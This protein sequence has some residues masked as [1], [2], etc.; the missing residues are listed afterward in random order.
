MKKP[1]SGIMSTLILIATFS[2]AVNTQLAE[3]D[4]IIIVPDQFAT[5]QEAINNASAGDTIFV[6]KGTYHENIIVNKSL[7]LIDN[8]KPQL[9]KNTFSR[10][11]CRFWL[12]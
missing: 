12:E 2:L 10:R 3:A 1:I 6:R 9:V 8:K 5:I 11:L 7:T 4:F